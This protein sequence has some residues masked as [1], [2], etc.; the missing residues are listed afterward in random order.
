M[1]HLKIANPPDFLAL[2]KT[3]VN[4]ILANPLI[5]FPFCTIAFVQ[6]FVLEILYFVPR[7]PLTVFFGPIIR[8]LWAESYLHYPNY[9]VLLPELF[10]KVQPPIYIFI[11]SFLFAVSVT[12][13]FSVNSDKKINLASA[14]CET[15]SMYIHVV[16]AAL[17]AYTSYYCFDQFYS[18][19]SQR[20]ILIR[21]EVG[22]F[23]IIKKIILGGWSYFYLMYGVFLTTIFAFLIPIIVIEKKKIIAAIG[24]NFKNLWRSFW[25]VW[26][27]VFIPTLFYLP[28][29]LL[30][31]NIFKFAG[32]IPGI[33]L[34]ILVLSVFVT[35]VIDAV[36]YTA[37]TTAYLLKKGR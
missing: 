11:S 20:A 28:I 24:L 21:S 18:L 13:I 37:I 3:S 23:F 22:I 25:F 10:H 27:I 17:V 12:L 32:S 14:F 31:N 7:Y 36:V 29:L 9:L 15:S 30:R 1:T 4:T 5:L 6:L 33:H 2:L 34:Y 35:I 19:L 16:L 26:A 8:K